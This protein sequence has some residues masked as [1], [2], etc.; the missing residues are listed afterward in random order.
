MTLQQQNKQLNK[1]FVVSHTHWDREWY[2]DFQSFRTRLVYMMDELLDRLR[3]DSS[4]RHFMLDG[5]TIVIED[6]LKIRPERENELLKYLQEG[7]LAAGPWYVM[8]DEFLVS[9]ESLVRNLLTGFRQ[10]R[11]MGFEPMKSGYVTDIFGHNSQMP[12]IFQGFGI[13]NAVLFRG[14]YGNGDPAEIWWEGADGSR[15]L[16]LKLDE[17]RSYSDFY[18]FLRWPFADRAFQY[19]EEELIRRAEAML[20]YKNKRATTNIALSL[21]GCDHIEIE[22][23]LGGML[24]R[25]NDRTSGVEWEHSTIEAYLSALRTRIGELEVF[26]GEQRVPGYNGVNNMVLANVLSSRVH[27][28][29]QNQNCENLLT[30][31]AEPWNSFASREGRPYPKAFL[32]QAWKHLLENHPHDSICGCSITLVHEDMLY[33]FAQ[34]RSLGEGM[35]TEAFAY[36][37]GHIAD[38]ALEGRHAVVLFNSSQRPVHGVVQVELELPPNSAVPAVSPQ[39]GGSNFRLLDSEGREVPFQVISVKKKSVRRWRPYR[40][41]PHGEQVDRFT[42]AF[43]CDIPAFGYTTY[44]VDMN[45]S[46]P[47][48]NGEYGFRRNTEPV[49]YIG[50]QQVSP[51]VWENGKIRLEFAAN[52][53]LLLRDLETGYETEGLLTFEDQADIGDGWQYIAPVGNETVSTAV[54][55]ASVSVMHD[56]PLETCLRIALQM[57]VPEEIA[58]ERTNRSDKRISLPVTTFITLRKDDPII[59]CRTIVDNGVRDHRLKLLFPTRVASNR[60]YTGTPFDVVERSVQQPDYS[61]H[62]EKDSGIVPSNGLLAIRSEQH[63]FAIYSKGLYE[64]QLRDDRTRTAAITLYRSTRDEVLSDGGD[65]GQLLGRLEFEYAFRPFDP[66]GI[67]WGDLVTDQQQFALGIRTVNRKPGPVAFETLHRR[68]SNLPSRHSYLNLTGSDLIVSACK[69]AEDDANA[70]IIRLWNCSNIETSGS[71]QPVDPVIKAEWT[72]LD[73]QTIGTA[74]VEQGNILSVTAKPKEIVTLKLWFS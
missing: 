47:P 40:D 5:Q 23:N 20:D 64:A 24:E 10:S 68:E 43:K 29:Q 52:G 22:P 11:K 58:P 38:K 69:Q 3:E 42:V 32:D 35:L 39:I 63:G 36:V 25:L 62:M 7:R 27:L 33:R 60:Y 65:G 19:E 31:W 51:N 34:S 41:I 12:Q 1:I 66:A 67:S 21:D 54:G 57:E 72:N 49:R 44:T 48:G 71:I 9:G 55:R 8:P 46:E 56:G 4:Y 45:A 30:G 70:W 2:Q 74:Q 73:E 61:R 26:K 28:K 14:F 15:V 50:S 53:T 18:F 6:Y 37:S 59:R 13:D 16:G 17:D